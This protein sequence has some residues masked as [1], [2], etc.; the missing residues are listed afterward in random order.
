MNKFRMYDLFVVVIKKKL[1][2]LTL[3]ADKEITLIAVLLYNVL[4]AVYEDSLCKQNYLLHQAIDY[5][6]FAF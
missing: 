3:M 2:Y 1:P 4:Y 5:R 6:K